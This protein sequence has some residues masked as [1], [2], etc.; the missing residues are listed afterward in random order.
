TLTHAL[1]P[2]SPAINA[3]DPAFDPNAFS[4]PQTNDQRGSGFPRVLGTVVD[5]GAFEADA[6]EI[7]VAFGGNAVADGSVTPATANGTDFGS[8]PVQGGVVEH[9]FTITNSGSATLTVGTVTSTFADF[10]ITQQPAATVAAGGGTTT[11]KVA[12]DPSAPGTVNAEI[13]FTTNDGNENPFNFAVTGV[14]TGPR[15]FDLAGN[16]ISNTPF[17]SGETYIIS[18]GSGLPL[19]PGGGGDLAGLMSGNPAPQMPGQTFSGFFDY[20]LNGNGNVLA[21]MNTAGPAGILLDSGVFSD[22]TGTLTLLAREGDA[23]APGTLAG[24]FLD[25]RMTDAGTGFFI[26]RAGGVGVTASNDYLGVLDDGLTVTTYAREGTEFANLYRGLA[27]Q[28]G[29]EVA[30]FPASL[31]LGGPV[32]SAND[33]GIFLI[34]GV[35][36]TTTVQAQEGTVLVGTL[37]LGQLGTRVVVSSNGVA[38][39]YATLTG[40]PLTANAGVFKQSLSPGSSP[41]GVAQRSEIAPGTG[42][43]VFNSFLGESINSNGDV[44]I[45]AALKTSGAVTSANDEGL[46]AQRAG[47]LELVIREGDPVAGAQLSRVDR[48]SY[49]T[50]GT[51]VVRGVLKGSGVSSANDGVV[52]AVSPMGAVQVL[53]REGDAIAE[54]GNSQIAAITRFDVSSTGHY[55]AWFTLVTGTGDATAANNIALIKSHLGAP[56]A[57]IVLR[58][59]DDYL[60]NSAIRTLSGFNMTDGVANTAGG[61]GGQG[62]AINDAGQIATGLYFIDTTQGI[63]VGP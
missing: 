40:G 27:V 39:Y 31:V 48:H 10:S 3:G 14:G 36:A 53:L 4:P 52:F 9:T 60:V 62:S 13:S 20:T 61:T 38:A 1:L 33:T 55:T 46:W 8:T 17:D 18:A 24:T 57:D 63:F 41:Q 49:L 50:D 58:K 51:V 42:G 25:F 19:T 15:T 32:T 34:D 11:F 44:L 23:A 54:L 2:S 30:A 59:G 7:A 37:K 43:E 47:T 5:I 26:A 6:P 45:E 22:S 28:S 56:S 29:G 16:P 21:H 12:F 35:T